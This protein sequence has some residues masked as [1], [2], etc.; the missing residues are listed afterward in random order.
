M[1]LVVMP[2]LAGLTIAAIPALSQEKRD[3]SNRSIYR[4]EF[5]IRDAKDNVAAKTGRKYVLLVEGEGKSTMRVG[6]RVP[7]ASS[8]SQAS[9]AGAVNT[10]FQYLDL[11]VNIDCRLRE[12]ANKIWLNADF[13][14]NSIVQFE[15][16][17]GAVPNPTISSAR[18]NVTAELDAGKTALIASVDD[19]VV[20]RRLDVE[21]TVTKTN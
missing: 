19:P 15:K 7:Y 4:V 13:D 11:G 8:T 18:V 9:P 21:A 1:R 10:Q 3:S 12:L 17:A 2:I 5:N 20:Q 14:I 6:A 16:S